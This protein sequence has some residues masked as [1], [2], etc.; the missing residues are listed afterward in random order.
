MSKVDTFTSS[1]A[2]GCT[3]YPPFTCDGKKTKRKN[4]Y[5][6]KISKVNF[7]SDNEYNASSH[8]KSLKNN[9]F[10]ITIEK[11]CSIKKSKI[12]NLKKHNK[13]CKIYD[14]ESVSKYV[15]LYSKYVKSITFKDYLLEN[16]GVAFAKLLNYYNFIL[17]VVNI[18]KLYKFI[19]ND[20]HFGNTLFDKK[21][22]NL[23]LIDFGLSIY[24]LQKKYDDSNY[25]IDFYLNKLFIKFDP[26]WKFQPIEV[27][28]CC[29][30]LYENDKINDDTLKEIIDIYYS[31]TKKV[32]GTLFKDLYQY[33]KKIFSYYKKLI[34]NKKKDSILKMILLESMFTWDLYQ[35]SY[36]IINTSLKY[37]I[38]ISSTFVELLKSSLHYDYKKRPSVDNLKKKFKI[39]SKNIIDSRSKIKEDMFDKEYVVSRRYL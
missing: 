6:S 7:Y 38:S 4:K 32:F 31:S 13:K 39:I 30:L 22:K 29:Y 24:D 23:C 1:G 18:L 16:D 25:D 17:T 5:I 26:E 15:I 19:H 8:L 11:K 28:L 34:Q 36:I 12:K 14:K 10:F 20:L 3:Y 9:I 33:K 2:Y 35:T 21:T 27:H 37:E